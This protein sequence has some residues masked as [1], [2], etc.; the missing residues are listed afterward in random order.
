MLRWGQRE[1][2]ILRTL[3]RILSLAHEAAILQAAPR[4]KLRK[5][6]QRTAKWDAK[7]EGIAEG[8]TATP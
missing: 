2:T 6:N 8:G 7:A 5:E 4:I 3:R 1:S